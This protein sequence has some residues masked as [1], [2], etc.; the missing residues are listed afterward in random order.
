ME[1]LVFKKANDQ[2]EGVVDGLRR[3]IYLN[4]C[5]KNQRR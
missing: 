5:Q 3:A 4:I 2:G 1:V